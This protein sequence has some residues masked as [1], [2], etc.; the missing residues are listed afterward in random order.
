L[1]GFVYPAARQELNVCV[2]VRGG[3]AARAAAA[4]AEEGSGGQAA[5]TQECIGGEGVFGVCVCV[6]GGG[7]GK[8]GGGRGGR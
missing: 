4:E 6:W 7:D 5:G 1:P 2:C 3:V 8:M